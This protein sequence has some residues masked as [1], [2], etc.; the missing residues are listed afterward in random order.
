MTDP[1]EQTVRNPNTAFEPSDWRVGTVALVLLGIFAVVV[2][3]PL[4][5][6][7]AYPGAVSDVARNIRVAPP[8][9]RL[10]VNPSQ[11][12]ANFAADERRRSDTYYWIDK[13]NGVVHIPIARAMQMLAE[14]G[15]DGF[16]KATP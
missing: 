4:L 15:I 11:D 7:W 10:E 16:P 5:L 3:A 14:Q 1:G 9:P 2:I 8:P 13:Q 12:L 6:L